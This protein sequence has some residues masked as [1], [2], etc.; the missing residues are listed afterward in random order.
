MVRRT[1]IDRYVAN[2]AQEF[3]PRQV[4][5]FGSYAKGQATDDSDVDLLVILDKVSDGAEQALEI[6]RRIPRTFPLDLLVL[7]RRE[8]TRRLTE[9]DS[10][11][12]AIFR[13]GETVYEDER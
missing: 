7:S 13:D 1:E 9:E 8:A 3:S 4:V 6:R 5:L 2:L 11:F 12:A 10:F